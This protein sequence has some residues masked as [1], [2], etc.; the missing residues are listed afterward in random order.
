[1]KPKAKFKWWYCIIVG[2]ATII[3]GLTMTLTLGWFATGLAMKY[4]LWGASKNIYR[5]NKSYEHRQN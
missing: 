3:D 2:I 5:K 4:S 1:M